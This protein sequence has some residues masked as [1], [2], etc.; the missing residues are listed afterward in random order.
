MFAGNK[1]IT[2]YSLDNDF[3]IRQILCKTTIVRQFDIFLRLS[4]YFMLHSFSA[5]FLSEPN[6]SVS[7]S[8]SRSILLLHATAPPPPPPPPS[9]AATGKTSPQQGLIALARDEKKVSP[10]VDG[11]R[12]SE[13]DR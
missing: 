5:L 12:E 1:L 7:L 2:H 8:L 10:K 3:L 4:F 13:I 9:A 11:E 6:A